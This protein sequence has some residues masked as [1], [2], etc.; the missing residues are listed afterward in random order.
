MFLTSSALG[1][2]GIV[3]G[4]DFRNVLIISGRHFRV[5]DLFSVVMDC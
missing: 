2:F 4:C 1:W 5:M 3:D